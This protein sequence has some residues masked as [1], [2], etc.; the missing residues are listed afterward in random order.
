MSSRRV[1]WTETNETEIRLRIFARNLSGAEEDF[2]GD[3]DGGIGY[4]VHSSQ[5]LINY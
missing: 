2:V 3:L 4:L 5:S 1:D